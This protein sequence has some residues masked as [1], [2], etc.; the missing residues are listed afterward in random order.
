MSLAS[1]FRR[2]AYR[3]SI[4]IAKAVVCSVRTPRHLGFVT[5]LLLNCLTTEAGAD[6]TEANKLFVESFRLVQQ[7]DS[8]TVTD[9]RIP[10]YEKA[11]ALLDQIVERYPTTNIGVQLLTGQPIGTFDEKQIRERLAAW[12]AEDSWETC[13]RSPTSECLLDE[14]VKIATKRSEAVTSQYPIQEIVTEL[15]KHKAFDKAAQISRALN[16]GDAR[17]DALV[18]IAE[19]AAQERQSGRVNTLLDEGIVNLKDLQPGTLTHWNAE[20][21]TKLAIEL[22]RPELVTQILNMQ[23]GVQKTQLLVEA[24]KQYAK[25]PTTNGNSFLE[26]AIAAISVI[27]WNTQNGLVIDSEFASILARSGRFDL[28][29]QYVDTSNHPISSAYALAMDLAPDYG[30]DP[31]LDAFVQGLLARIKA[32]PND[33]QYGQSEAPIDDPERAKLDFALGNSDDAEERLSQ[34]LKTNPDKL[35]IILDVAKLAEMKGKNELSRS[36]YAL[37]HAVARVAVE[38]AR[39]DCMYGSKFTPASAKD[40]FADG[41]AIDTFV[42]LSEDA[43][44][45]GDRDVAENWLHEGEAVIL[46]VSQQKDAWPSTCSDRSKIQALTILATH[47]YALSFG[48]T[49]KEMAGRAISLVQ[50]LAPPGKY[51]N[52]HGYGPTT[53]DVPVFLLAMAEAQMQRGDQNAVLQTIEAMGDLIGRLNFQDPRDILRGAALLYRTGY[54]EKAAA[55]ERDLMKDL[56]TG[57]GPDAETWITYGLGEI[58]AGDREKGEA[59]IEWA[60]DNL[61]SE[62]GQY[63]NNS[64]QQWERVL[65]AVDE[66]IAG[67]SLKLSQSTIQRVKDASS[68]RSRRISSLIDAALA[69]GDVGTALAALQFD[70]GPANQD[71]V[72]VLSD[73]AAG[74]M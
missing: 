22:Q 38:R 13:L 12:Q 69:A 28:A 57:K 26:P 62:A 27:P 53:S 51:S 58:A 39:P 52:E 30:S 7:A 24:T 16:V 23:T 31:K 2:D 29:L 19:G 42:E 44:R 25:L 48:D 60:V 40:L 67:G 49:A 6:D 47:S 73:A 59:K 3:L 4:M 14:A 21:F 43:A 41:A 10:L 34:W 5:V 37:G 50:T 68:D 63:Y 64:Y 9:E 20:R 33:S 32:G 55:I 56:S 72:R 17:L 66:L 36:A 45:V 46:E 11:V 15:T 61:V 54:R 74:L 35:Q 18:T 70:G 8:I 71:A 1:R 65:E